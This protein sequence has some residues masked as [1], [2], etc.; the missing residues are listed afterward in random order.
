MDDDNV[1][2]EED[3]AEIQGESGGES[4]PGTPWG[5]SKMASLFPL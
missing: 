2:A 1:P 3:P 5:R 4:G